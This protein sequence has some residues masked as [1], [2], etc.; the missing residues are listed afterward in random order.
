MILFSK[1]LLL[2]LLLGLFNF[3]AFSQD[4]LFNYENSLSFARFLKLSNQLTFAA[5][6]YER[7]NFLWPEDTV[8]RLELVQTYRLSKQCDK[9]SAFFENY[10]ND[11]FLS[12]SWNFEREYLRYSLTCKSNPSDYF[13]ITSRFLDDER[14]FYNLGYYWINQDYRKAF[15]YCLSKQEILLK[16]HPDLLNLTFSFENEKKKSAAFAAFMSAVFPGSG[17]AYSKR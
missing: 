10:H 2:L 8:V 16:N 9:L 1:K 12:K 13:Q 4:N 7:L 17:K 6:E 3:L 5:E 15:D 14:A 11:F